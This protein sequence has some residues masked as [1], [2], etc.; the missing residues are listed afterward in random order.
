MKPQL[1]GLPTMAALMVT[2]M[3]TVW[4]GIWGPLDLSR[5]GNGKP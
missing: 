4:L 1:P 2:V 5:I 3:I